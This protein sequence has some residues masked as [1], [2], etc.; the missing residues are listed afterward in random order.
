MQRKDS[1]YTGLDKDAEDGAARQEEKEEERVG[2]IDARTQ[3][4]AMDPLW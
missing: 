1:G 3:V 4:E 2:M